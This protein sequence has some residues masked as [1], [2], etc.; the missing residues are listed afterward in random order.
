MRIG[1]LSDIHG[2]REAL[3][4]CLGQ[5]SRLGVDRLVFLGDLVGYGADPAY[6]VDRVAEL[7]DTQGALVL[8]GNHDAAAISANTAGMND[9]ARDAILW[10]HRELDAAQLD[11]LRGL[12]T[13]VE[14]DDR[15]YVHADATAPDQWRYIT[16]AAEAERSLRATDKRLTFCGHVHRPALYHMA[17]QKP[18]VAFKPQAGTPIPLV[19]NRKWLLVQGAVGQPRDENPAASWGVLDV[20]KNEFTFLRTSYDIETAAG[21]IHAAHLPQILAARLYIGR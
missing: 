18:A 6:V 9:Y 15:L 21:K 12:K 11:F 14:D 19:G 10:T 1:F 8:L 7:Q 16:D 20:D 3:D 2:N 17:A 4:A 13:T 5:A